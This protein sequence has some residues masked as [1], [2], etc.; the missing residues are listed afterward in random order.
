MTD[1]LPAIYQNDDFTSRFLSV[2]NSMFLDMEQQISNLPALLDSEGAGDEMV[3]MLASWV[4][5]DVEH[6][7]VE[8][9]RTWIPEALDNYESMYTVEGI[10]RSVRRLTGRNPILIEYFQ[11]DPNSPDC[12]NPGTYRR[13]YGENPFRFFVLLDEDTFPRRDNIQDFLERM[14][15]LIPAGTELELVLLKKSIQLDWHTYLGVNS[16]VGSYVP[17]AI[18]ENTTIHFETVIG[19]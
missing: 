13:L 1:Y 9:L 16:Y 7:T 17:V 6:S 10:R 8:E 4:C 12:I 15:P 11:V 14:Q 19:G 2:F 3:R 5:E 18:D